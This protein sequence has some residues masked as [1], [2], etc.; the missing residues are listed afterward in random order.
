MTS[1]I[2]PRDPRLTF[3]DAL[4]DEQRIG[5]VQMLFPESRALDTFEQRLTEFS[6]RLSGN[7][8]TADLA[9]HWAGQIDTPNPHPAAVDWLSR[10]QAR[11]HAGGLLAGEAFALAE[12]ARGVLQKMR[13]T[14]GGGVIDTTARIVPSPVQPSV[15]ALEM[16]PADV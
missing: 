12:E 15:Q 14:A 4:T 5:L 13:E 6:D 11:L 3:L 7:G 10:T 8:L 1:E 16:E 9:R 2:A